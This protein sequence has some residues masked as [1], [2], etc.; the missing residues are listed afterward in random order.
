MPKGAWSGE[1]CKHE[2]RAAN[3]VAHADERGARAAAG[4]QGV[5]GARGTAGRAQP[6]AKV[7]VEGALH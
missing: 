4:A 1:L 5:G 3:A 6:A 2:R 7:A